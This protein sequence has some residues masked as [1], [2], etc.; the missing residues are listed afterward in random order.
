MAEGMQRLLYAM[1]LLVAVAG[2]AYS[3]ASGFPVVWFAKMALP[4][5][6]PV[7]KSLAHFLE[8]L[9][10]T[11]AFGLAAMTMLHVAAALEHQFIKRDSILSRMWPARVSGHGETSVTE[12]LLPGNGRVPDSHR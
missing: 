2:W 3:S 7:D 5:I 9:H 1:F 12:A 10:A 11:L 6:A 4:D 8:D